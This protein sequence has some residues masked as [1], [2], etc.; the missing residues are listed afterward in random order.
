M[1]QSQLAAPPR[2]LGAP[3]P[4]VNISSDRYAGATARRE[5]GADGVT[6]FVAARDG[7]AAL[8]LLPGRPGASRL[9][10]WVTDPSGAPVSAEEATVS[11]ARPEAGIEP[12]RFPAAMPR[13]GVY[14]T[15]GLPMPLAGRWRLRL[16]LLVDDFTKL[17]FEGTVTVGGDHGG[18]G[19]A[20]DHR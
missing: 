11:A 7:Q 10:A 19:T 12:V 14:V 9:E 8:T 18:N 17:T 3:Q 1:A 13:P 4:P 16:D 6:I 15:E 20:R 2:P 5:A